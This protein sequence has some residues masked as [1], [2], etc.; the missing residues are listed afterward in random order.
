MITVSGIRV[1]LERGEDEA[2]ARAA[3]LCRL[4]ASDIISQHTSKLSFDARHGAV[5]RV[6][7][8]R[9]ELRDKGA[10]RRISDSVPCVSYYEPIVFEPQCGCEKLNGRPVVIGFG[11]AGIFAALLLARKGYRPLVLERG[12]DSDTRESKVEQFFG[13]GAFDPQTNVQF[14]EGG[15]GAFS[16]GKLTTRIGDPLCE[17][18]SGALVAA[19]APQ[20]IAWRQKPHIGTDKLRAV[21]KQLRGEIIALGGEVRF[22][23]PAQGF[24]VKNGRLS[25]VRCDGADIKTG[26][27][28]IACGHS[29]RDTFAALRECGAVLEAKPFSVG[30]RIEHF[31]SDIDRAL[32]GAHAGDPRLPAGEYALS[33]KTGG[34]CVYTFCMCP[35]GSVVA[36]ASEDG[37]IVTNGMSTYARDGENANSA[38]AVSLSGG[39]FGGDPFA[40]IEWQRRLENGAYALT[41]SW[42]APATDVDSFLAARAGLHLSGNPQPTYPLGVAAADFE[43]LFGDELCGC[44]RSGIAAFEH[45]LRGFSQR[46]VLTAPETRTSSPVRIVRADDRCAVGVDGLYPCG[47]GAGYAGGIMSAAVD[48]LRTA[49]AVIGRFA[50]L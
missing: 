6:Y 22:G 18:V 8:V 7:S 19:G 17:Y 12:A 3:A 4:R 32:Y 14:G 27:A 24:F 47:E 20:D 45:K 2:F 44:L 5:S 37:G 36:A 35:G 23:A 25:A 43:Q 38:L 48:G 30:A 1:P 33:Y 39:D 49:A 31:Q 50:P 15:A 26:A 46:A 21:V 29:A 9:L 13:G 10:E 16:D 42:R 41:D 28:I 34:R 40:A 11:P